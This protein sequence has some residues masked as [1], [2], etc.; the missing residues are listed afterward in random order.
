[1]NP[2]IRRISTFLVIAFLAFQSSD[3]R[4]VLH[5]IKTMRGA[6]YTVPGDLSANG[7][8]LT[9]NS[10]RTNYLYQAARQ[11]RPRPAQVIPMSFPAESTA[12][13]LSAD[14]SVVV[15]FTYN[16][17]SVARGFLWSKETGT[18]D[19][20]SDP[21]LYFSCDGVSGNGRVAFGTYLAPNEHYQPYFWS[22]ETGLQ[23]LHISGYSQGY[24]GG[25]SHDGNVI[26][27]YVGFDGINNFAC[28]W[29][30][31]GDV[32][33]LDPG[34]T[35]SYATGVTPDGSFVIGGQDTPGGIS[36]A[37]YWGHGFG[38]QWVEP[39]DAY[40]IL[41]FYDVAADGQRIVGA[42]YTNDIS[43]A[44]LWTPDDGLQKFDELYGAALP[45]GATFSSAYAISADGRWIA[46]TIQV[47]GM[48][49]GYLLD[50]GKRR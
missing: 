5:I 11:V 15:G 35:N 14:G 10:E 40:R 9:L 38:M 29:V 43:T 16:A 13:G 20:S 19:L 7:R 37:F 31:R 50:T 2:S 25:S 45:R 27:G 17:A 21:D 24:A 41:H 28:R 22:A 18:F 49:K 12:T 46:G 6:H 48:S 23:P 3:A 42:A 4:P 30:T 36:R 44:V 34:A 33:L 47:R 32:E 26:V 39:M 1:M 8:V